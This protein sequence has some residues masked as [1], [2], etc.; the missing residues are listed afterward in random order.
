MCTHTHVHTFTHRYKYTHARACILTHTHTHSHKYSHTHTGTQ[1]HTGTHTYECQDART[2]APKHTHTMTYLDTNKQNQCQTF[3]HNSFGI[4][5]C[6][7]KIIF[8]EVH[9]DSKISTTTNLFENV[10]VQ[11]LEMICLLFGLPIIILLFER[12]LYLL[13]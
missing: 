11:T 3:P 12:E 9:P 7:L 4:V 5:A 2:H 8:S 1:T 6:T 13:F 10:F